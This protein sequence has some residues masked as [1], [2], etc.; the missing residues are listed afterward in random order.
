[1]P[2]KYTTR[3]VAILLEKALQRMP[4]AFKRTDAFSSKSIYFKLYKR[5]GNRFMIIRIAD[6]PLHNKEQNEHT[7]CIGNFNGS[8]YIL[9]DWYQTFKNI[10]QSSK[11]VEIKS[12]CQK[13]IAEEQTKRKIFSQNFHKI[14]QNIHKKSHNTSLVSAHSSKDDSSTLSEETIDKSEKLFMGFADRFGLRVTKTQTISGIFFKFQKE[15]LLPVFIGVCQRN[16]VAIPTDCTRNRLFLLGSY[17]GANFTLEEWDKS[18]LCI[19]DRFGMLG[20][21]K[22]KR[23]K[24]FVEK[25]RQR[26]FTLAPG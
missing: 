7:I 22:R 13:I 8:D 3:E 26:Q 10:S 17:R 2:T 11:C 12:I 14:L 4:I 16:P 21:E 18:L 9:S 5:L 25:K 1:M 15:N 20:K 23:L 19:L 24:D 6:H